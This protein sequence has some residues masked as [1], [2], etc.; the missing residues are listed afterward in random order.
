[1]RMES[2][3]KWYRVRSRTFLNMKLISLRSWSAA[4]SQPVWMFTNLEALWIPKLT[5]FYR[6]FINIGMTT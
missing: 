3:V 4:P 1:M 2:Q 5:D 6:G